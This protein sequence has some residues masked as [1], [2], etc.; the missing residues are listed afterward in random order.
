[1]SVRKLLKALAFL[2]FAPCLRPALPII[3][4][5]LGLSAMFQA[6]A[7]PHGPPAA[8]TLPQSNRSRSPTITGSFAFL[9]LP[10]L[11]RTS[12]PRL[13]TR[14]SSSSPSPLSS[15]LMLLSQI[16]AGSRWLRSVPCSPSEFHLRILSEQL[17]ESLRL[18]SGMSLRPHLVLVMPSAWVL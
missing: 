15:T 13:R 12:I 14:K 6:I 16:R 4:V 1:M 7:Y 5:T 2:M 3:V 8:L 18:P 10:P 9:A 11:S 17:M